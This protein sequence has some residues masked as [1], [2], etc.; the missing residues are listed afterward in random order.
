MVS[1]LLTV[2]IHIA[3]YE[4]ATMTKALASHQAAEKVISAIT[5]FALDEMSI[6]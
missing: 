6:W 3:V 5:A 2:G 4:E 1:S